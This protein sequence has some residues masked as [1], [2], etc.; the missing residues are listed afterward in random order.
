MFLSPSV[1]DVLGAQGAAEALGANG[2]VFWARVAGLTWP[3]SGVASA[4]AQMADV[5]GARVSE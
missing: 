3:S 4:T 2:G 5:A 1:P